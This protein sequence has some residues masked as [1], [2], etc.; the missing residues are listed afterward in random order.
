MGM[1]PWN[2]EHELFRA[3]VRSYVENEL[4]PH[5]DEWEE[6]QAF[7]AAVFKQLG[8][9]GYLG[10]RYPEKYGGSELDYWYT[11]VFCEELV[12]SG[13]L[14]LAVDVM[15]QCEFAVGVIHAVGTEEQKQRFLKP[16]IAG[17]KLIALGITEPGAGSDVAALRTKAVRDGDHYIINGSKTFISN[18]TRADYVTLAVRTGEAG[19]TGISLMVVPAD[20]A[21]YRATHM[22]K[23][24]VHTSHTAELFFEACR[25]PAANL[26]AN[27]GDGFKLIMT[28]FQGERLVLAS[29]ANAMM[30]NALELA[31]A[32]SQERSIFGKSL[33]SYQ[34]WKH[35]LA[36]VMTRIEASRQLT[37]HACDLLVKGQN[38]ESAISM[39]KLFATESV[40]PVVNE[41]FQIF[42][43][44]AFT[45][46]YPISRIYRD[47]AAMTIGAGSSEVMREII[48][49]RNGIG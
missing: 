21:G 4:K 39:A 33:A 43:G 6:K 10:L 23:I 18:G 5:A 13:M 8:E 45:E 31:R 2:E 49:Q 25:V 48:A 14:G 32:Y 20:V 44:Y 29:F 34:I 15:V 42:G 28:H 38:P 3:S 17:E 11:V 12:R 24:G 19:H 27:E 35:R 46:D 37:Y 47:V 7:P 1:N 26:L 22:R 40:K 16:A 9:L 36:D 30:Q 41:C